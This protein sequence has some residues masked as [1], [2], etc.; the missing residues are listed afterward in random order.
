MSFLDALKQPAVYPHP[1]QDIEIIETH[2]S[3]VVL[4]GDYAYKLKKPADFGFLDFRTLK[5]R[6]YY[7]QQEVRLNQRLMPDTYLDV[8]SFCGDENQLYL[9]DERDADV[10]EYAVRMRQFDRQQQLNCLLQRDELTLTQLDQLAHSL[11]EFHQQVPSAPADSDWGSPESIWHIVEDNF[12]RPLQFLDDDQDRQA[13][14]QLY[15]QAQHYFKRLKK[16]FERRKEQGFVRE[17][18]GDLHLTN[19]T[20]IDDQLV[21]F[22]CLEFNEQF[23]WTDVQYDLAF[24]LMD[25]EATGHQKLANRC[26]NQYL[27]ASGDYPGLSVLNFY[28]ACR[29]TITAKVALIGKQLELEQYRHY[30]ALACRYA[31]ISPTKLYLMQGVSGS[32]KSYVSEKL[33]DQHGF[34]WLRADTERKRIHQQMLDDGR[35]TD[36]YGPQMNKMTLEHLVSHSEK[37]LADGYSLIV[38]A[39]HI[40]QRTRQRYVELAQSLKAEVMIIECQCSNQTRE[41]RIKQRLALGT[42]Q[43]D[44]SVEVMNDQLR[45]QQ[46]LTEDELTYS[47]PLNT[48]SGE[49][50]QALIDTLTP[51][52]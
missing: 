37:I 36:L 12:Q 41:Q 25:L 21:P 31:S 28:K 13:S 26:L 19:I 7:C 35:P 48:E 34:I 33:S 51:R 9:S 2:I 4:T 43:S 17:C 32:G 10:F 15:Q 8:V 46:S 44:A 23:R 52:R 1:V 20:M 16:R 18:H 42:D 11:A 38:D 47:Y 6:H 45:H 49:A 29:A 3:W 40:N 27:A 50:I 39:V 22:D 30:F 5:Q 24:L 14:Q